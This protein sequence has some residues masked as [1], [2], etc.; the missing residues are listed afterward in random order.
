MPQVRFVVQLGHVIKGALPNDLPFL[1]PV[2]V[3]I[4]IPSIHD[5]S[6]RRPDQS[7]Q[8]VSNRGIGVGSKS[9]AWQGDPVLPVAVVSHP[10]DSGLPGLPNPGGQ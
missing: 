4:R 9:R 6:V 1:R 7:C 5:I 3:P 8:I 2:V 10:V